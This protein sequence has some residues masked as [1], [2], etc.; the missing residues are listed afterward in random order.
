MPFSPVHKSYSPIG[1]PLSSYLPPGHL[2]SMLLGRLDFPGS[3]SSGGVYANRS[4]L[5]SLGGYGYSGGYGGSYGSAYSGPPY[6]TSPSKK[7]GSAGLLPIHEH[8]SRHTR[9]SRVPQFNHISS[10]PITIIKS[11]NIAQSVPSSKK[12]AV[13]N[14]EDIDVTTPRRSSRDESSDMTIP[15][16]QLEEDKLDEEASTATP[17]EISRKDQSFGTIRRGRTVIRIQTQHL[18]ENPYL[19]SEERKDRKPKKTTGEKLKE[20]WAIQSK[21]KKHSGYRRP[22]LSDIRAQQAALQREIEERQ[23]SLMSQRDALLSANVDNNSSL[24][25]NNNNLTKSQEHEE[26]VFFNNVDKL[27]RRKSTKKFLI[28]RQCSKENLVGEPSLPSPEISLHP[29]AL[30]RSNSNVSAYSIPEESQGNEDEGPVEG[31]INDGTGDDTAEEVDFWATE[32]LKSHRSTMI[33]RSFFRPINHYE[34]PPVDSEV[35]SITEDEERCD[36]EIETILKN[37]NPPKNQREVQVLKELEDI[38]SKSQIVPD[39]CLQEES[40]LDTSATKNEKTVKRGKKN[41]AVGTSTTKD[42]KTETTNSNDIIELKTSKIKPKPSNIVVPREDFLQD[43]TNNK[44]D[45]QSKDSSVV[46]NTFTDKDTPA[47]DS[48][49]IPVTGD[50]SITATVTLP[51]ATGPLKKFKD[52]NKGTGT[53]SEEVTPTSSPNLPGKTPVFKFDSSPSSSPTLKKTFGKDLFPKL[54]S[55]SESPQLTKPDFLVKKKQFP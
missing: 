20:K 54:K 23:A 37:K 2:N 55:K 31:V 33:V 46:E 49:T 24:E 53:S 36:L 47:V 9:V 35:D 44:T 39:T 17:G 13:F 3:T 42:E 50:T 29:V 38:F 26:K 28:V 43:K 52:R 22:S 48:G 34:L 11:S 16:G 21:K 12:I 5:L 32:G 51:K 25:N 7:Y 27:P 1:A 14:T 41:E 18:K 30:S 4:P 15:S 6:I 10:N 8:S 19:I 45:G 40:Q